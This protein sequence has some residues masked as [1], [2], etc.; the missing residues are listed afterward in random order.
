[1]LSMGDTQSL[2]Q[3]G[4]PSGLAAVSF[5]TQLT[6]PTLRAVASRA[7]PHDILRVLAPDRA[8]A[9]SASLRRITELADYVQQVCGYLA[10]NEAVEPAHDVICR[11]LR[12][13]ANFGHA[14]RYNPIQ[15]AAAAVAPL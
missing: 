7:S 15:A 11:L 8:T 10:A 3:A 9:L 13:G 1:M 14:V 6:I 5:D 2:W 12:S 4:D